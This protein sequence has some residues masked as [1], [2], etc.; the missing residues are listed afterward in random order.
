MAISINC[1]ICGRRDI[2][3]HTE[4]VLIVDLRYASILL[5]RIQNW[6]KDRK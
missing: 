1:P 6:K 4:I 5:K 2:S 3:S